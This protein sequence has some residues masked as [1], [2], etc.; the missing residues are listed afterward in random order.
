MKRLDLLQSDAD[1]GICSVPDTM[2]DE[3]AACREKRKKRFCRT[4]MLV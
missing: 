4:R 3:L 2:T 1:N